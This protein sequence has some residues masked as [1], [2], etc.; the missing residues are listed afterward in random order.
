MLHGPARRL[1]LAMLAV[2]TPPRYEDLLQV[3]DQAEDFLGVLRKLSQ[4][5]A[6]DIQR[7]KVWVF[8]L[9]SYCLREHF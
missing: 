8:Q 6:L 9:L 2:P 5:I 1:T 7:K 4:E 3:R